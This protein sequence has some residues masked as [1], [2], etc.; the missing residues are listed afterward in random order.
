VNEHS[1]S[2]TDWHLKLW[3]EA[4]DADKAVL[5]PMPTDEDDDN[6]DQIAT[7][8]VGAT[9]TKVTAAPTNSAPIS[10]LPS[11]HP[12]RPTKPTATSAADQGS[13][14]ESPAATTSSTSWLPSFLSN[15]STK[16]Q[17]WIY[18]AL[19]L[20]VAF[21]A[22]L[23]AYLFLARRRRLRNSPRDD[24]EFELLDDEEETRG[25]NGGAAGEKRRKGGRKTRGG[26]LYD[27][28]AG[29]SD[30]DDFGSDIDDGGYHDRSP[31][32]GGSDAGSG[33]ATREKRRDSLGDDAQHVIGDSDDDDDDDRPQDTRLLSR[34]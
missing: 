33:S 18:G 22:G 10:Q 34:R 27:A 24:Y 25:L 4:V 8:T 26:E 29:E 12:D 16:T 3:G 19:G 11:D 28:F 17:I 1:G 21:C 30:D 31:D 9:T 23:G 32:V 15:L 2:F 14:S 5:L 20:I 13:T 7:T 6:H